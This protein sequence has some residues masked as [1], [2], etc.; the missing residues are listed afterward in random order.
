MC[1]ERGCLSFSVGGT[2][3]LLG[4]LTERFIHKLNEHEADVLLANLKARMEMA[5]EPE[6]VVG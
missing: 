5:L 6:K 3:L 4:R 1:V 2:F